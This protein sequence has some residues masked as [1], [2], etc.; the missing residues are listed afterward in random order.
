MS[1]RDNT[2]LLADIMVTIEKIERIQLDTI[3]IASSPLTTE[4]Q[5]IEICPPFLLR[6]TLVKGDAPS[7]NN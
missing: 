6:E 3:K 1:D 7:F 5:N 2:I 4:K